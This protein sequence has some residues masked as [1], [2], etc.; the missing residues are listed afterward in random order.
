MQLIQ[1]SAA[2][3]VAA[4]T[5]TAYAGTYH[6]VDLGPDTTAYAVN[7][8][9]EVAGTL[10]KQAALYSKGT[11]HEHPSKDFHSIANGLDRDGNMVGYLE[12]RRGHDRLVYPLYYPRLQKNGYSIPLPGGNT[13]GYSQVVTGNISADGT[14]VTGSYV[15]E[16]VSRVHCFQWTPGQ[17][18]STDIGLP[19]GYDTCQGYDVNKSGQI[20]GS[21]Y[22]DGPGYASFIYSNGAFTVVGQQTDTILTAVNGLG[23]ATGADPGHGAVLWDGTHLNVIGPQG[24]LTLYWGLALNSSDQVVGRGLNGIDTTILLYSSGVLIDL[25][26]LID[27]GQGWVWDRSDAT[28]I[29]DAGVIVG[30][31]ELGGRPHAFMLIPD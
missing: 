12:N 27:D 21:L 17:P 4:S 28:G 24:S 9:N 2:F 22:G 1:A 25:V 10:K 11:W 7:H 30:N 14:I 23:H 16:Q 20:V 3:A 13:L 26:P 6:I 19:A 15:D 8:G 31:A 18:Q 29:T 5:A